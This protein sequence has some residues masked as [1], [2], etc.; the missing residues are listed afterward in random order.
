MADNQP[1]ATLFDLTTCKIRQL[2]QVFSELERHSAISLNLKWR[3]LEEHFH[4]LEKSLKKRFCELE[5]RENEYLG[6]VT[7]SHEML[8]KCEAAVVAKELVSLDRLQDKRDA[9]LAEMFENY[10]ISNLEP[11]LNCASNGI[12]D[13][14][15]EENSDI[16]ATKFDSEDVI[17]TEEAGGDVKPHSELMALCEEMNAKGLH[18]FISDNRKNLASIREEVPDA[19]KGAPD[20]FSLVLNSL[21]DFYFGENLGLGGKRDGMLLGMRRTCLML[22]ESLGELLADAVTSSL[23]KNLMLTSDVKEQ[24][25]VIAS[26]WKL[27]LDVLDIDASSG[28][29]LEAHAFLQL[30]ATF[31]IVSEFDDDELCKLVPS[32]SRRRQTCELCQSLGLSQKMPGVIQVLLDT[33][34]QIDAINLAYAFGLTEQFEPVP[35]LK[36][37]LKEVRKVSYIKAGNMSPG[38]LDE[39]NEHELSSLKAIIKCI[40]EHKLEEQ[41]PVDPLQKRVIQL[42]KAKADKRTT[43]AA[44]PQSKRACANGLTYT[45][46][47]TN[48]PNKSFYQ[49]TTERHPY[50]HGR[51]YAYPAETRYPTLVG[52]TPYI[53]PT[54]TTYYRNGYHIQYRPPNIY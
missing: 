1:A 38:A 40:E 39:M 15:L 42:E 7:E 46:R 19:L 45:S 28:N 2:Q 34:R 20:P 48:F 24:A 35:L 4:G 43:E 17:F 5:D 27:K 14:T 11:T 23:S 51:Q 52:S 36:A 22:M 54:N 33:G 12:P 18:K 47:V 8:G 6:K 9:A 3:E 21:N 25:K 53:S 16:K 32:V 29:S 31:D 37:Y 30:L 26:D 50:L 44:K 49:A 41:C 10:R 13:G